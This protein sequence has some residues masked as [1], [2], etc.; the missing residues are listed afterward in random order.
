VNTRFLADP[1][2]TDTGSG[3]I[4]GALSGILSFANKNPVVAMGA[5]QAGG[6]FL[7]GLTSTLTPAQAAQANA[8]AAANDAAA[9]LTKQQTA[10]LAMPKSVA[11]SVPVTGAPATLVP[12]AATP[13]AAQPSGLI[14][15]TPTQQPA[16][17]GMPA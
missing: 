7:S 8:Q 5:I 13:T 15:A 14:N 12:K 1:P 6:S 4:S 3:G 16:V 17:T 11:S 2:G 9:A 10:N